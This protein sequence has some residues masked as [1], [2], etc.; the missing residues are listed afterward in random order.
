VPG[1][2][3]VHLAEGED[4]LLPPAG[5][6][7]E[8]VL[9]G[10]GQQ[11]REEVEAVDVQDAEAVPGQQPGDLAAGEGVE[12]QRLPLEL[13]DPQVPLPPVLEGSQPFLPV[14]EEAGVPLVLAL[15]AEER[16]GLGHPG[17]LGQHRLVVGDVADHVPQGEDAVA[18]LIPEAQ[19]GDVPHQEA[20]VLQAPGL[21]LPARDL[22]GLRDQVHPD[23]PAAE[24]G[25]VEDL[26]AGPAPGVEDRVEGAPEAPLLEDL[27]E[28]AGKELVQVDE[29]GFPPPVV[30]VG[31]VG[32]ELPDFLQVGAFVG[33]LHAGGIPLL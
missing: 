20:D 4:G 33:D 17:H 8:L 14:P 16:A 26:A 15:E 12:G 30:L 6:V 7:G 11:V 22:E 23:D 24:V 5:P 13:P 2:S 18:T 29:V 28:A 27:P 1:E 19:A 10:D 3:Q 21:H 32:V 25:G 31:D 9:L